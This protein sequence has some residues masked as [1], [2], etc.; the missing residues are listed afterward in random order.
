[1]EPT[2]ELTF[3]DVLPGDVLNTAS[4]EKVFEYFQK[5]PE[6]LMAVEYAMSDSAYQDTK[7]CLTMRSFGN[8]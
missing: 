8:G 3:Q 1:M 4:A 7:R 2:R 6:N 5:F